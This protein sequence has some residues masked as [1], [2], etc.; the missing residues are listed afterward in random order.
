MSHGLCATTMLHSYWLV[1]SMGRSQQRW[2][3]WE[4]YQSYV[5]TSAFL[6]RVTLCDLRHFS[7][8][9]RCCDVCAMIVVFRQTLHSRE[10]IDYSAST[11]PNRWPLQSALFYFVS[12]TWRCAMRD[13]MWAGPLIQLNS[14]IIWFW[15]TRSSLSHAVIR[16]TS[17]FIFTT[18]VST[19]LSHLFLYLFF[20]FSS[21]GFLSSQ[22]DS[23]ST[24]FCSKF[25]TDPI[26]S[27]STLPV[28]Q[29]CIKSISL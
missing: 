24:L 21:T 14:H 1:A 29:F 17:C 18:I 11:A 27:D 8:H 23:T 13:V 2:F 6:K 12:T 28:T 9:E 5:A 26:I 7:F 4:L 19:N 20:I 3:S 25:L 16:V 22:T 15:W 10:Q